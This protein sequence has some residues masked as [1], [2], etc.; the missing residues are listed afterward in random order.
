MTWA[1]VIKTEEDYVN[2]KKATDISTGILKELRDNVKEGTGAGFIN[3]LAYELCK[4]ANVKPAF[5]GV[6][7]PTGGFPSN[8]CISVN[9]TILHGIPHSN[10]I[11][12]TGDLV[13][14][15]FG[16]IYKGFFTDHCV[17]KNIGEISIEEQR[18]L[19]TGKLCIDTAVQSAI[20]GNNVSDIS[21]VL[22]EV[23]TL[24][25]FN[26][27]RNYCGHGIG[28]SLWLEPEVLT[29]TYSGM[30]Q[31]P[32]I[33]GMCLCIEN[34]LTMGKSDLYLDNDGW[35]LK[36]IDGSK[37]VMFEHMVIVRKNKPEILTLLD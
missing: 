22:E 6:P 25:G 35:S 3:D 9:D 1:N 8:V 10:I 29:Y 36:T 17:T 11:F 27:V 31:I 19:N 15:D 34:Q 26:F 33:E 18:L 16:I 4:K 24:A 2:L 5:L 37:G 20:V 12:K 21:K 30:P 7:S 23:A 28:R 32:L 13:K 14:I